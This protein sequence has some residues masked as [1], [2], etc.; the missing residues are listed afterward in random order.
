VV[1]DLDSTTGTWVNGQR[2]KKAPLNNG[3]VVRVGST[4][5][6]I[7]FEWASDPV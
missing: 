2:T 3:D 4:E 1:E 6:A 5:I 7:D